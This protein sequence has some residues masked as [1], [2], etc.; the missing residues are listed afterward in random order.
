MA[1]PSRA[2]AASGSDDGAEIGVLPRRSAP[3]TPPRTPDE[4]AILTIWRE[5]LERPDIGVLDD[6]FDLDGNSMH[7]IK[8]ISRIREAYGVSIRAID[9]FESPTVAALAA[10]V[11]ANA[12]SERAVVRPRRPDAEPVLS[13]DQH[14]LWLVDQLVPGGAYN[15]H[16][17]RRL[18]GP[19]R[20][21]VLETSIREIM[22]RHETLRTR[23][24]DIDG[25]P[26]Q[27]V[28]DLDEEWR[29]RVVDVSDADDQV[30]AAERVLDEDA[31]A[32][33]DLAQ[34]PL[35]RALLVRL[36]DTDHVLGITAHHTVCDNGS[37]ALFVKELSALY[38]ADGDPR[39]ADLPPL[40]IQYRDFAVWQRELLASDTVARQLDY[41]GEHLAGAPA[42]LTLPV[43]E[44]PAA[45][46]GSADSADSAGDGGDGGS[47]SGGGGG[48]VRSALPAAEATALRELCRATDTTVFMALLA[49]LTAVLG[50]WSGQRDVVVGVPITGR[51]DAGTR[52]LIG[53]FFNTLPIRMDL[54]DTTTFAEALTRARESALGG[55]GN[56]DVPLD[57]VVRRVRPPRI[58]D[59][60]PL[61]QVVL[62]VVDS[63][64]S[65]NGLGDIDDEP[66]DSP[67]M[68]SKLDFVLT[69]KELDGEIPLELE[70]DADRYDEARMLLLLDEVRALLRAACADPATAVFDDQPHHP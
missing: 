45:V 60:T 62:N 17:R 28:D 61:F 24:P 21:A 11:A 16:G 25:E 49:A 50:R 40:P 55:Y 36:S 44:R 48:R 52:G 65:S 67:V 70:F 13:F 69:G 53:L 6:F 19:L 66:M 46:N 57:L 10:F 64:R 1:H 59:R 30:R 42:E 68:P 32:S 33:C 9:F 37:V 27:V 26:L 58:A 4:E 14:R 63:D 38:R 34:G 8:V 7:A 12:P 15:V 2:E 20:V 56:A 35:F 5:V 3:P 22:R 18:L 47:G 51:L 39:E 23:F 41:W 29:L 54:R 31:M 43:A